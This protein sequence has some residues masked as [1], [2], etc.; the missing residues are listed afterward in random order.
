MQS[1][2]PAV[3]YSFEQFILPEAEN[4]V[5]AGFPVRFAPLLH[6]CGGAVGIPEPFQSMHTQACA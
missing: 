2:S 4:P 6:C 3:L 1:M 5:I